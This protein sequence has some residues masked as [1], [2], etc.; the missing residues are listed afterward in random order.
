MTE[1]TLTLTGSRQAV[2][3]EN[4][5]KAGISETEYIQMI[6][7]RETDHDRQRDRAGKS[8]AFRRII[9]SDIGRLDDGRG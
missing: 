6:A 3:A 2:V 7:D 5:A 4:A 1:H 8:R 9:P